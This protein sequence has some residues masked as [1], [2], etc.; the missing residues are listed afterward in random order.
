MKC[1]AKKYYKRTINGLSGH[2]GQKKSKT[3]DIMECR[4][5]VKEILLSAKII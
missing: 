5:L 3:G 2:E 4:R 1:L